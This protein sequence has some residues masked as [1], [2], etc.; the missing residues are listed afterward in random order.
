MHQRASIYSMIG[1]PVSIFFAWYFSRF[2]GL[3]GIA[4]AMCGT[5]FL[6]GIFVVP[7]FYNRVFSQLK[8]MGRPFSIFSIK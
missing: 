4:L 3:E 6:V 8:Q 2:Y 7:Q 5:Q 1:A